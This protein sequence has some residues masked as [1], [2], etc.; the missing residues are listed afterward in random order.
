MAVEDGFL[1]GVGGVL[2]LL[3]AQEVVI[4]IGAKAL[5]EDAS[6]NSRERMRK[7]FIACT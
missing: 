2:L 4:L 5:E 3:A 7:E 1:V 6:D